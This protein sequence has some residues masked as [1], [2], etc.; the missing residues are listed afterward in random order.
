ML[1]PLN[2]E[3]ILRKLPRTTYKESANVSMNETF[4]N[5]LQQNRAERVGVEGGRGKK[6]PSGSLL[7][8]K[9]L[10]RS[11]SQVHRGNATICPNHQMMRAAIKK[12]M[13]ALPA[14]FPKSP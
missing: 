4:I 7:M 3:E 8:K 6:I 13:M 5:L 9:F 1:F 14:K 12:K 2:C 11:S 10:R